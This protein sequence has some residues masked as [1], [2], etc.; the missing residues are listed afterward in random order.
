MKIKETMDRKRLKKLE[1]QRKKYI[2][3]QGKKARI[4]KRIETEN[5][6]S[7]FKNALCSFSFPFKKGAFRELWYALGITFF[8]VFGLGLPF[9][10]I[11]LIFC[12][13]AD[14]AYILLFIVL[15]PF[16]CIYFKL[17][18]EKRI[19]RFQ[20]KA[21]KIAQ[22]LEKMTPPTTLN[23]EINK[24]KKKLEPKYT[25]TSSSSRMR[26]TQYYKDKK[27]E[28]YRIYMG[29]PPKEEKSGLSYLST[30]TS[31]DLHPGDY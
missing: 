8:A 29:Y 1:K 17:F 15:F 12:A 27:D 16:T 9:V 14:L 23:K 18:Q 3:L 26:E 5:S 21:D 31:L 30:D 19:E 28:Y 13:L 11:A 10:L 20:K 6:R 22:L 4:E 24:I 25:Y 2:S 7:F